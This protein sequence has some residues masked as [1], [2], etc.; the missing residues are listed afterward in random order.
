[1]NARR[2]ALMFAA[3]MAGTSVLGLFVG[4]RRLAEA[5]TLDLRKILPTRFEDWREDTVA[6]AFVR[7]ANELTNR[8]YQQLLERTFV[9]AQGRRVMLSMAYGR[10]QA[11]SL[12]LHWPEVCYRY[13]GYTVHGKHQASLVTDGRSLE[14]TRLIAELPL[15]PEPITYWTVLGGQHVTDANTFR[16]RRLAHAVRREIADGL[17]VRVSSI[18]PVAERG[19]ELQ[20][21]FIDQMLRAMDPEDRTRIAGVPSEG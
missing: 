5:T 1:V 14:V 7:P 6:A 15:R 21:G 10:E 17:L 2:R 9:D 13:A 16:L 18:D 4:P 11:A 19:Y 3:G 8:L 20:A 12:E